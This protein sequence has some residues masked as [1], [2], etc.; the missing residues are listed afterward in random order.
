MS[1]YL[2]M[3]HGAGYRGDEA[4]Q[5]AAALEQDDRKL[6]AMGAYGDPE[7]Q[8]DFWLAWQSFAELFPVVLE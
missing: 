8:A 2:D 6:R 1:V 3:A 4:R 7:Y 5:M